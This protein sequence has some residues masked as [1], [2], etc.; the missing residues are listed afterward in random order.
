MN[1]SAAHFNQV[2]HK[3]ARANAL[4]D[5]AIAFEKLDINANGKIE[6]SKA[7]K[8]MIQSDGVM[9]DTHLNEHKKIKI[10]EFFNTYRNGSITKDEWLSFY[11][12]ML[13]LDF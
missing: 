5:A 11:A 4:R 10:N 8:L 3:L 2:E 13:D 12:K 1:T 7:E 6:Y 9:K